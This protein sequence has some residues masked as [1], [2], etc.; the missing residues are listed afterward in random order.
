MKITRKTYWYAGLA[1]LLLVTRLG[2]GTLFASASDITPESVSAGVNHERTS[3]SIAPLN[4]NDELAAA[5]AYKASDMVTRNYFAHQDPEGN[6]TWDKDA[7]EGYTPYTIL[8]ENLAINFP[9]ADGLM[10][11][12][13]DSPE[14]RENILNAAFQDQGVGVT[15]GNVS[16]GQFSIAIANEFGALVSEQG[17]VAAAGATTASAAVAEPAPAKPA[18]TPTP[19]ATPTPVALHSSPAPSP[20]PAPSTPPSVDIQSL[21]LRATALPSS[22][23]LD[24]SISAASDVQAITASVSGQSVTLLPMAAPATATTTTYE[25]TIL[26]APHESFAGQSLVLAATDAL[27]RQASA[28]VPLGSV[29]IQKVPGAAGSGA[30]LYGIF[31]DVACAFA[32]LFALFLIGDLVHSL[33]NRKMTADDIVRASHVAVLVIAVGTMLAVSWW[34]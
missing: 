5:A 10:S 19:M 14:H 20:T 26:L 33:R 32:V 27:G 1:G 24:V 16:Q 11:A 28:A 7:A 30:D 13:M 29:P 21:Q 15:A 2:L 12:W 17:V 22:T 31:R 4:Y 18:P 34:H 8:G 3:R 9:D 6:F 25:G 23:A